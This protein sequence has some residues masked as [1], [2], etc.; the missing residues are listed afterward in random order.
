MVKNHFNLLRE[1]CSIH[2]PSG[3]EAEIKNYILKYINENQQYFLVKPKII[4]EIQDNLILVFGR[5]ETVIFAHLDSIGFTV[6]Y[7]DQLVPIGSPDIEEG[8]LLTGRDSLGEIECETRIDDNN[9]VYYN[10]GRG[11]E[12]GTSLVFKD[13][14][15]ETEEYIQSQYIDNRLGVFSAI[16][17]AET[18]TDGVIAFS[19]YEENGGGS[20]PK[21]LRFL[22]E[23][24]AIKNA[25]IS[26]ITWATDGVFPGKGVVISLRDRNIPRKNF[27]DKVRLLAAESGIPFQIEVEGGGSSDGREVQDSPYPINWCFIGAPEENVHS[28]NEK[29]MKT[30]I[31]S[32]IGL[33]RFLMKK[34]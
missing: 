12:T 28:P 8:V 9:R 11:I 6:R 31:E 4:T 3:E 14:F 29:V 24:Y 18:L 23:N 26:D 25:L 2:G 15:R 20:V 13:N 16:K 27:T 19:T 33:Y 22:M 32:M 1:L 30:D 5:P 34:L 21:I 10:F 7:Q 17:V